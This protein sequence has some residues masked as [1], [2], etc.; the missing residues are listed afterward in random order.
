MNRIVFPVTVMTL[1]VFVFVTLCLLY[2]VV[3]LAFLLLFHLMLQIGL[4][5]M[6]VNILKSDTAALGR[7]AEKI[8]GDVELGPRT[9]NSNLGQLDSAQGHW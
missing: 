1:G 3:S 2:P 7:S 9:A 5:W 4:V 8:Y 6:V